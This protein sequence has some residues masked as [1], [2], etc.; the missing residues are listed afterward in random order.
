MFGF[1][2]K[3]IKK[4]RI[5]ANIKL[6]VMKVLFD[7]QIFNFKYGGAPKYFAM[8]LKHMP[9]DCWETTCLYSSN[10]YVRSEH[11]FKTYKYLFRGQARIVDAVNKVYTNNILR[12]RDYDVFHQTNF[13]TYC[14]QS[15]G[16]KPMVTTFHDINLSTY[17]PHPEIVRL[18]EKSL[19]RANA[20][21]CVSE[22]T[23]NDMLRLFDID[24]KKVKV[25]YHGIEIP[26]LSLLSDQ[27]VCNSKYIL[28]VGRRSAYKNFARF[29]EAFS[30]LHK[31]YADVKVVCTSSPFNADEVQFF[32]QLGISDCMINISADE[33]TMLRLYRDALFFIFPSLYEGFGMPILEAWSC[34]CPVVLSKASCFPEIAGDAGLYFDAEDVEDIYRKMVAVIEDPSL[35][36][37]LIDKGKKRIV[38]FSWDKCAADHI[39]LYNSLV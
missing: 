12:M 33:S 2:D 22:N 10:E 4:N 8:L 28:Y 14:F 19:K 24:E 9:A 20:V 26:D 39:E 31:V 3:L 5:F 38:Q 34:S 6:T 21:V 15:I 32:S 11:L 25:I 29:I 17:D 7:H 1:V 16:N 27:R 30:L 36:E 18:Q 37:R 23:K 13:G 35:R